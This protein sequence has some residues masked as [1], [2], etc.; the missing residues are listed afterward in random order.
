M[1]DTIQ[2]AVY[3]LHRAEHPTA[4]LTPTGGKRPCYGGRTCG[5]GAAAVQGEG[6]GWHRELASALKYH[7]VEN[8]PHPSCSI[9][10]PHHPLSPPTHTSNLNSPK[11]RYSSRE[12]NFPH[13]ALLPVFLPPGGYPQF[14]TPLPLP[15]SPPLVGPIPG[16]TAACNGRGGCSP[17]LGAAAAPA[18]SAGPPPGQRR[19]GETN[20]PR[21]RYKSSRPHH[22]ARALP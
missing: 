9:P 21:W 19:R 5:T 10:S 20:V 11:G 6:V 8:A 7:P 18:T 2:R 22:Q 16:G 1:E 13:R 12:G 17:P 3:K 14:P 15:H 4:Q